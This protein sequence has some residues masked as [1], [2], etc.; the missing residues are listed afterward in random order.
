MLTRRHL[1]SG[2]A[3]GSLVAPLSLRS[4]FA[5]TAE[6]MPKPLTDMAALR[7]TAKL[8]TVSLASGAPVAA[9]HSALLNQMRDLLKRKIAAGADPATAQEVAVCPLCGCPLTVTAQSSF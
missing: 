6:P 3:L 9:D 2:I 1:L 8:D 7:C 5:I 4:A